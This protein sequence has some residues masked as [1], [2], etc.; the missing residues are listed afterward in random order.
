M[1]DPSPRFDW[2]SKAYVTVAGADKDCLGVFDRILAV[3]GIDWVWRALEKRFSFF[4]ENVLPHDQIDPAEAEV[5][6]IRDPKNSQHHALVLIAI[7]RASIRDFVE[8]ERMGPSER[9]AWADRM[10]NVS[11]ELRRLFSQLRSQRLPSMAP[12][13]ESVLSASLAMQIAR[14][15]GGEK[16]WEEGRERDAYLTGLN[17]GATSAA[18]HLGTLLCGLEQDVARWASTEP[19]VMRPNGK[20]AERTY[21]IRRLSTYFCRRYGA[22][23]RKQTLILASAFFDVTD[24]SEAAVAKLAPAMG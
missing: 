3:D 10:V 2:V 12:F 8:L 22:P 7:C 6:V 23:L 20:N 14:S 19:L 17:A 18:E 4:Y 15:K 5:V 13:D 1:T 11:A 9:R 21:F 24:L 16:L